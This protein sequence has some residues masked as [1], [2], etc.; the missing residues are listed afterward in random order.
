MF[1]QIQH[2]QASTK[3][4]GKSRKIHLAY[5]LKIRSLVCFF[6]D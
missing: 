1:S 2:V 3:I 4:L 5:K 6:K